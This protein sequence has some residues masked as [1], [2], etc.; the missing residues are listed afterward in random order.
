MSTHRILVPA[1]IGDFSWLWSKFSTTKDSYHI[2]YANCV[3]DRLGAYLELLP[4]DKVLSYKMSPN[5]KCFF[6]V[7]DLEMRFTPDSN[8]RITRY[9]QMRP[10]LLNFVEPNTHLEHGNRIE[11]WLP[12]IPACDLHYKMEGLLENP[13]KKK[14]FIVHLSS[15]HTFK[16]WRHYDVHVWV[17][18]IDM[19][20]KKT[21]WMPVFIGG[22]YDDF[23][24]QV[25][26][27]YI[28]SHVAHN[29]I[30]H[31]KDLLS[32]LHIVQQ[33]QFFLGAVSSGMTMLANVMRIPSASW[34]PRE[35]LPQSWADHKV[36]YLWMLW[37]D[38]EDDKQK[39]EQFLSTL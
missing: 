34:W 3:P 2:E 7:G 24:K 29:L 27:Q 33:C 32:A 18:I 17:N 23:A 19:L 6:N 26:D 4:K 14:I 36:P 16:V 20:Q 10:E 31:T 15:T 13:E 21:G 22:E 39:L 11:T 25:F 38:P 5:Y 30:G 1:G 37:K 8:P 9:S 35:K 28:Q 12:D